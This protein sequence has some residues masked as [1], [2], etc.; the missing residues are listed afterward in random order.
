MTNEILPIQPAFIDTRPLPPVILREGARAAERFVEFFTANIRNPN[1]RA[2]YARAVADFFAWLDCRRVSLRQ[3]SPFI[4]AAYVEE[5]GGR[6]A[7]PSVKQHLAGVR[8]L[9]DY[10]VIGQVIP[11]NPAAS[12]RGPKHVVKR[13]KTPVLDAEQARRLLDSIDVGTIVGLRDR[14]LVAVMVYSFA[15][16]GAV[17]GLDVESYFQNGKRWWL[18]LHEKESKVHEVPVHHKAEEYLDAYIEAADLSGHKRMPLF[19]T[20]DRCRRLTE[21]RMQRTEVL[22]MIKRRA[23]AAGLPETTCC[24]TFRAT[25]ITVYLLN[26]GTVEKAQQIAGHESPRTT[27]L[28]DRTSDTISLDEVERIVLYGIVGRHYVQR[29][30]GKERP[31][32]IGIRSRS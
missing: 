31:L 15:R 10:L 16:V 14:A 17:V 29:P 22:L 7:A 18:R 8:M 27:K 32:C 3:V 11:M 5:L 26:G 12:V 19:R 23:R 21:R 24:H 20:I 9:F 1:T 25:G 13:G 2:A 4:V 6:I 28:Y 30:Y